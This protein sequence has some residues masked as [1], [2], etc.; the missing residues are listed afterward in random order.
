M[1]PPGEGFGQ[2]F[3]NT[4]QES[5]RPPI[6]EFGAVFRFGNQGDK[7]LVDLIRSLSRGQHGRVSF[8]QRGRHFKGADLEEL[9]RN[10]VVSGRFAFGQRLD[11][12]VNLFQGKIMGECFVHIS[13]GPHRYALLTP[14]LGFLSA[15]EMCF[16]RIKI[17]VELSDMMGEIKLAPDRAALCF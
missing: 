16:R 4:P 9:N 14:I 8:E 5:D 17:G 6:P 12:F 11:R 1:Q 3:I 15:R 10:P 2:N 13:C 7:P